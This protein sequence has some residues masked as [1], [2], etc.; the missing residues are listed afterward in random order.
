MKSF[1]GNAM[2]RTVS[3]L[4]FT[5]LA[6]CTSIPEGIKPV[7]DFSSDNYLGTWYEVARFDHS[8]ERGLENVTATYTRSADGGI[9]VLNRGFNQTLGEWDEA[10]G[11]AYFVGE[12]TV[13]HLKVS[14][15]GPFYASYIVMAVDKEAYQYSLVTGPSRDYFWILARRPEIAQ[16]ELNKLLNFAEQQGYNTNELIW[17]KH[18]SR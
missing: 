17:V 14:F 3:V 15:F 2:S 13:G 9:D 4:L 8:F 12:Q 7:T 11:K 5:L 6:G 1:I 16:G 18:S 10:N